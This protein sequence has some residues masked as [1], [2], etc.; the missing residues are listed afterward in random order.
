MNLAIDSAID[1]VIDS[2]IDSLIDSVAAL[3]PT[4]L[5]AIVGAP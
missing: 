2:V 4:A 3:S 1:S 5:Q